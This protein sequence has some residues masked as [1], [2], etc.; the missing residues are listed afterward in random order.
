MPSTVA[1]W[2]EAE[3]GLKP[4]LAAAMGAVILHSLSSPT[5]LHSAAANLLGDLCGARCALLDKIFARGGKA[6]QRYREP[7]L[8]HR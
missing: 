6:Y 3:V 4:A 8:P 1:T 7:L 5:S 2:P